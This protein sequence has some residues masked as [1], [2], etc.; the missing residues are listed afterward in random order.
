MRELNVAVLFVLA[1]VY[2]YS[3]VIG[4]VHEILSRLLMHL[5]SRQNFILD[6]LPPPP[7]SKM[8]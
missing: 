4:F 5:F 6:F 8:C 2:M 1:N 7:A 3:L